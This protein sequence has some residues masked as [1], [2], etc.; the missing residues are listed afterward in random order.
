[1][2]KKHDKITERGQTL[3]DTFSAEDGSGSVL[4]ICKQQQCHWPQCLC[5]TKSETTPTR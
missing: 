3:V 2:A 1:M 4:T 5:V